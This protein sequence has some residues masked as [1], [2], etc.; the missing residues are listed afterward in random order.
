MSTEIKISGHDGKAMNKALED[1]A[2]DNDEVL[3]LESEGYDDEDYH[4]LSVWDLKLMMQK[5]YMAGFEAGKNK[6]K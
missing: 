3:T 1:I 4:N 2:Y 5:A 6:N